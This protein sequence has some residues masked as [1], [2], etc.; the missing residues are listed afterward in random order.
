MSALVDTLRLMTRRRITVLDLF[1][2][3]GGFTAGFAAASSRFRSVAAVEYD[4]QAAASYSAT[5]GDAGVYTGPIERWLDEGRQPASVDVVVGGPPCQ[6]FST[7]G[8]QDVEDARNT[9]WRHY[10]ETLVRVQP[11]YFVVENVAAFA[12]SR[13]FRDFVESTA[14]GGTLADYTF[15]PFTLNAADYGAP[16]ARRRAVL[17][18][19]HRDLPAVGAPAPTHSAASD[20]SDLQ[21]HRTVR[22]VLGAV[23]LE[24]DFDHVID[25]RTVEHAGRRFAGAFATRELHWSRSYS[26]LSMRRFDAIGEGGNRFDLPPELLAPCWVKHTTGSA[27]VMGRLHWDKPSVTIRTEFHKPEKGRYLHPVANRALTHYEAALLQGFPPSH[28]FVG[29]K[30][31]IARQIGNAVP[32]PLGAALG[33]L[34]L[35]ALDAR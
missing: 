26:Q 25:E 1:A 35:G 18:G 27:D 15:E 11:E 29:S 14:P 20:R 24:P 5:F 8:K 6:G 30:V 22:D 7:L 28:K 32:I 12:A 31:S 3:A 34:L 23:P 13:Q 9:L 21:P 17:V 2:G 19:R 33:R 10:A 16:Q 4:P